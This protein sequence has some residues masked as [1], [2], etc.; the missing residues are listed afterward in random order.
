M[1]TSKLWVFLHSA[2]AARYISIN[3]IDVILAEFSDRVSK[4]KDKME[5]CL[6]IGRN[7]QIV[8]KLQCQSRGYLQNLIKTGYLPEPRNLVKQ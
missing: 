2:L 4:L 1:V 7:G 3:L 5:A 6:L 8:L